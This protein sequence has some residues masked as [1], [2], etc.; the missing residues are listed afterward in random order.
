MTSLE[1]VLRTL[2]VLLALLLTSTVSYAGDESF[3]CFNGKLQAYPSGAGKVYAEVDSSCVTTDAIGNPYSDFS[4]PAESVDIEFVYKTAS[5][6]TETSSA[7][8]GYSAYAIPETGWI[9]AGFSGSNK[10]G[11]DEFV[12]KDSLVAYSS[13]AT[14]YIPSYTD[15]NDSVQALS[16]IPLS[17]D[18]VHYALFTHIAPRIAPGQETLGQVTSSKMCNDLGDDVTLTASPIG[19]K[20]AKFAYWLNKMTKEKS[21]ENPITIKNI[22]GCAYY[23]AHFDCDSAITV[24]FPEEGGYKMVYYDRGY[25]I[26]S[27]SV[28]EQAFDYYS[29]EYYTLNNL[30]QSED[31][32]CFYQ[33]PT[34]GY[35]YL[36]GNEPRLLYGRGTLT[37]VEDPDCDHAYSSD[38]ELKWSGET[39]V[40]ID[41]L[42]VTRKYYSVDIENRQF[43]LLSAGTILAPKT[44]YFALPIESYKALEGVTEAP[45][46]IY[47]YDPTSTTGIANVKTEKKAVAKEGIYN[48]KGQK[49]DKVS[50][51]GLY[52][53]NGKKVYKLK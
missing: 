19:T 5:T 15:S 51:P 20:G 23:E 44:V 31:K 8:T 37:F 12:C 41:T 22:S 9:F 2:F 4:T 25:L 6:S 48:I 33:E 38:N 34:E 27:D 29:S 16:M 49:L 47:W 14:L 1:R 35:S 3:F 42:A 30:Q 21:T 50:E 13:K 32:T 7:S 24:E 17:P 46:V 40:N 11:E 18:T 39:G 52:I 10:M 43:K 26:P 45:T 53:I 36:Y 28:K